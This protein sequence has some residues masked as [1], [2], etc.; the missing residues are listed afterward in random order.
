MR[1]QGVLYLKLTNG[2]KYKV[3]EFTDIDVFINVMDEFLIHNK[4]SKNYTNNFFR[5]LVNDGNIL[6]FNVLEISSVYVVTNK[7]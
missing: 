6:A 3:D 4:T 1:S 2:D 5:L 7:K